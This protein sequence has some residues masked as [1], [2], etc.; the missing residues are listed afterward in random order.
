VLPCQSC[1]G[2]IPAESA[3]D[4]FDA[5]GSHRFAITRA[6]EDHAT[7]GLA[8]SHCFSDRTDEER[9]IDRVLRVGPEVHDLMP[10]S[11]EELLDLLFIGESGMIR[12][13][14]DFHL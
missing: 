9:V 11:T 7:L 4:S 5:V 8:T 10:Q 14:G 2:Y 6:A 12:A 1:C 3:T 13:D